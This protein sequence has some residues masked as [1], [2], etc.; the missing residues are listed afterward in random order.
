MIKIETNMDH[1][2]DDFEDVY[3]SFYS[4]QDELFIKGI[5]QLEIY[6]DLPNRLPKHFITSH[7]IL[8]KLQS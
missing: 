2:P 6:D 7:F 8:E 4:K 3:D 1:L 5:E